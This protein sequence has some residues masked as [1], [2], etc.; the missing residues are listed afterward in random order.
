MPMILFSQIPKI[1]D[2]VEK[3]TIIL[4]LESNLTQLETYLNNTIPTVLS[5][6][7]D[8]NRVC[9]KPQYIKTDAIPKCRRDGFKISCEKQSLNIKTTPEIRC[10]IKGWVKRDGN[11][12]L[13]GEG[14]T[15]TFS[16]PIKSQITVKSHVDATAIAAA[17]L[18]INTIPYIRKDWSIGLDVKVSY[19]W[20]KKPTITLLN[21][22]DI[23][24]QNR[25]EEKLKKRLDV[26]VKKIPQRLNRLELK[27]RVQKI[28]D[29][30]Q[31]PIKV[32]KHSESY[33]V[34][35][36]D[37]ISYSGFRVIGNLLQT[38][39]RIEG[40]TNIILG[41]EPSISHLVPLKNLQNI[42]HQKGKF[43]FHLP[44][45]LTYQELMTRINTKYKD[46]Y[47]IDLSENVLSGVLK[48]TKPNLKKNPTGELCLTATL[49]YKSSNTFMSD[50][51]GKIL[52]QGTPTIDVSTQTIVF[53]N[54]NYQSQTDSQAFDTL[55]NLTDNTLLKPYLHQLMQISLNPTLQKGLDKANKA[56][57]TFS[58]KKEKDMGFVL[59][60]TLKKASVKKLEIDETKLILYSKMS[61]T[62]KAIVHL[63]PE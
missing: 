18:Y 48:L 52:I 25:V 42:P 15:L 60:A 34:F 14:N 49:H 57:R 19:V 24:I 50:I 9:L 41:H 38:T 62:I 33:L 54:L 37:A 26:L 6:V 31:K 12:S 10:D 61:G 1:K 22:I 63:K 45:A 29:K 30:V 21:G 35:K 23:S 28:W 20:S 13:R 11:L 32:D 36:P 44:I 8:I 3:S 7:H 51:R 5:E 4:P 2:S 43:R 56:L 27:K 17:T 16:F 40:K 59:K 47:S 55:I 53:K 46:G 39:L 58:D